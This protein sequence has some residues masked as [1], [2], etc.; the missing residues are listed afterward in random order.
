MILFSNT[1]HS[2]QRCFYIVVTFDT[3][4]CFQ[5]FQMRNAQMNY[6]Q[7]FSVACPVVE[8]YQPLNIITNLS[9]SSDPDPQCAKQKAHF[10]VYLLCY[11]PLY[12]AE[13]RHD[14]GVIVH[15]PSRHPRIAS[16]VWDT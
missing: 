8:S 15:A 3:L 4:T 12:L 14:V 13:L 5:F 11:H 10:S 6:N 16:R 2:E 7:Y 9:I 1:G